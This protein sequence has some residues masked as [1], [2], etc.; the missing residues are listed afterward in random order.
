MKLLIYGHKTDETIKLAEKAGFGIVEKN[1]DMIASV[2][3]DGTFMKSEKDFPEIPK[4][5]LKK[6]KTSKKG[7]D[8]LPEEILKKILKKQYKIEEEIKIEAVSKGKKIIGLNEIIVHNIDPRRAIRY[9]IFINS[10]KVGGEIIGDGVAISTPYG[11]TGYYRSIT[12]SFF[13]IGLGVAFNNST[14]QSDH[15]VLKEDSE[16]VVKIT[17]GKA[18]AYSDNNDEEIILDNGDEILI[19]KYK[20]KAKIVKLI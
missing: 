7:H 13:E 17:R 11:S 14:E 2:G 19:K 3:G 20:N 12:G 8:I 5:I 1:P 15:M 6:S 9:E 10:K 16:I 18:I 4:F